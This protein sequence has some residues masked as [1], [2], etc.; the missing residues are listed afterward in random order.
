MNLTAGIQLPP[1]S[2][3]IIANTSTL[4]QSMNTATNMAINKAESMG[5][6]LTKVG[7]KL[8]KCVTLPIVGIE[9]AIGKSAVSFET[10]FAKVSTLLDDGATNYNE[11]KNKVLEGSTKMKVAVDEYS[12]AVYQSISAGVSQGNAIEFTNNAVKLAK[13]GFTDAASAV[14]VLTTVINAYGLSAEEATSISDKLITTQN[15]GKT[16]VNELASSMGKVIPTA[17]NAGVNIDNVCAAMATMTKNGI[18]TA[19]ATTYYNSMLNELSTSGS[20]AD[21]ALKELSGKGFKQLIESGKSV[22]EI[23]GMLDKKAKESGLSLNDM[24]GTAEG[25]K[26]ALTIMKNDGA[27]YNE[28]LKQMGESAGATEKAFKKMDSTP[29]EKL[30][31]ALNKLKNAGI[32][33]GESLIPLI[34]K[35]ADKVEDLSDWL[36]GLSDSQKQSIVE[37]GLWV[38]AIGPALKITGSFITKGS[39]LIKAIKGVGTAAEVASGASTATSAMGLAGMTKSLLS[40]VSKGNIAAGAIIAVGSKLVSLRE[41]AEKGQ[42]TLNEMGDH[43]DDFSGRV[44]NG[45]FGTTLTL[46]FSDDYKERLNSI[47]GDVDSWI[48]NTLKP[49]QDEINKILNDTGKSNDT[50][51]QEVK[52]LIDKSLSDSINEYNTAK[53][54]FNEGIAESAYRDALETQGHSEEYIQE[55]TN[56][57]YDWQE[58]R[59]NAANEYYQE[60][61]A[62]TNE[63]YSNDGKITEDEEK[64]IKNIK[65]K[66]ETIMKDLQT[67]NCD[68]IT[69]MLN[70]FY[71]QKE[72][73]TDKGGQK[74]Y[75]KAKNNLEK[76]TQKQQ[77]ELDKQIESVQKN[78]LLNEKEKD[79]EIKYLENKKKNLA[80]YTSYKKSALDAQALYD[81]KYAAKYGLN[82]KQ[83]QDDTIGTYVE[84]DDASG[85]IQNCYF[86]NIKSLKKWANAN[87]ATVT[88]IKGEHGELVTVAKDSEGKIIGSVNNIKN[89][90]ALF[91]DEVSNKLGKYC[92]YVKNGQLTTDQAMDMIEKDL[93]SGKIKAE[94]FGMTD[95]QFKKVARAIIDTKGNAS[96]LKK[97]LNELNG[98]YNININT[99]VRGYDTVND[100]YNKVMGLSG[101]KQS[102]GQSLISTGFSGQ[103]FNYN[104]L[105]YVPYDGYT[106]RLHKGERVLTAEENKEYNSSKTVIGNL[107][108][109]E[110]F[111]NNRK[112]DV[113]ALAE[114][115]EFYRQQLSRGKGGN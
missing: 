46:K 72:D 41:Q 79:K 24:F 49:M 92:G 15:L 61:Q 106:A 102:F 87:G 39:G 111:N 52:Q 88:T 11:Y 97:K 38:A 65:E 74:I 2:V 14:D 70:G 60:L 89:A 80:D 71:N 115:L 26:A 63:Y 4:A 48:N 25:A 108:N 47:G 58:D 5:K 7:D 103:H 107:L 68:D 104:G 101:N 100:L 105:D 90:Y 112:Q 109:I 75:E 8:T 51:K 13:G 42:A 17:K 55:Y 32:K 98:D 96:E 59:L 9:T 57:Y 95:E 54:Q 16:T 28:M 91:G 12:D 29:A 73:I 27:E 69:N 45:V 21:T 86:N 76:Q 82:V 35:F 64:K 3:D 44:K 19:E 110:S 23:L 85:K 31:G 36:D 1:L 56:R 6:T 77:E 94:E 37:M 99:S 113:K 66:Y 22:T 84:I 33:M 20:S 40:L 30:A 18:Q 83:I 114:E 78:T 81:S 50:K 43:F 67:K 93:E 10:N 62:K 34:E 53:K